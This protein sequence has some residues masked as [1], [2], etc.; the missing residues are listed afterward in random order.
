MQTNEVGSLVRLF[1]SA[2]RPVYEQPRHALRT[3]SRS[4]QRRPDLLFPQFTRS[5]T[6]PADPSGTLPSAPDRCGPRGDPPT[7]HCRSCSDSSRRS[8]MRHLAH[9][10][11][12][13]LTRRADSMLSFLWPDQLDRFA[14]LRPASAIARPIHSRSM[15]GDAVNGSSSASKTS[16]SLGHPV[17]IAT[18]WRSV[19]TCQDRASA[20]T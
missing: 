8:G 3:S 5:S 18:R 12:P 7:A 16:P 2:S 17:A 1:A 4:G 10:C 20:T 14:R 9:R 15:H 19:S 6:T 13:T 11:A